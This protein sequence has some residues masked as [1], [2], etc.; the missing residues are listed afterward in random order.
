M[1]NLTKRATL[2]ITNTTSKSTTDLA[3]RISLGRQVNRSYS[4]QYSS[5]TTTIANATSAQKYNPTQVDAGG[6]PAAPP[7]T[8]TH[9]RSPLGVKGE[10]RNRI[11]VKFGGLCFNYFAA[12]RKKQPLLLSQGRRDPLEQ[13]AREVQRFLDVN[14]PIRP[15]QDSSVCC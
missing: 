10:E 15:M 6:I 9:D 3:L 1:H 4:S 12:G 13:V 7:R 2:K 14:P 8:S 5:V 11:V